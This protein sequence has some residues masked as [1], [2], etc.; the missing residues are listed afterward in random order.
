MAAGTSAEDRARTQREKARRLAPGERHCPSSEL[1]RRAVVTP[2][3]LEGIEGLTILRKPNA[4][5]AS[6]FN[7]GLAAAMGD[8]VLFLDA[9]DRLLPMA[10]ERLRRAWRPGL[11]RLQFAG[12]EVA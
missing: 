8:L 9:D 2:D 6:A 11:S 4:G 1:L 3:T 7:E 12:H 5:Q 10:V